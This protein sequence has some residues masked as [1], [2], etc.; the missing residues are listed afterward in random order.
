MKQCYVSA[1]EK[2]MSSGLKEKVAEAVY[3]SHRERS[4]QFWRWALQFILLSNRKIL[5]MH[6]PDQQELFIAA[7]LCMVDLA[8]YYPDC[9]KQNRLV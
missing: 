3:R 6:P 5:L 7:P 2:I 9:C 1:R 8:Y 4:P